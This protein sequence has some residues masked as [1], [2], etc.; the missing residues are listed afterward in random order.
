MT[1]FEVFL[2]D[3]FWGIIWLVLWGTFDVKF[4]VTVFSHSSP[5][6]SNFSMLP[7]R[8]P[9]FFFRCSRIRYP[10]LFPK[11]CCCSS[12]YVFLCL[13][14]KYFRFT[15]NKKYLRKNVFLSFYCNIFFKSKYG[16]IICENIVPDEDINK[17][18]INSTI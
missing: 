18:I 12:K 7:F 9:R 3:R 16:N 15:H 17:I 14:K 6:L 5:L 8:C 10:R 4:D 11:Y 1:G 13:P 2:Y